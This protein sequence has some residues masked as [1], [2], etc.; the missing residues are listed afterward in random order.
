[1]SLGGEVDDGRGPILGE[2]AVHQLP[3]PDPPLHE[4]VVWMIRD[5]GQCLWVAGVG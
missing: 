4:E 3:I 5:S 2:Q 1:M